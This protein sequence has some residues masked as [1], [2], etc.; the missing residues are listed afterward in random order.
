MSRT[1]TV[2][3][4]P[5]ERSDALLL[6]AGLDETLGMRVDMFRLQCTDFL[7]G[8]DASVYGA[9][10]ALRLLTHHRIARLVL[11]LPLGCG[12]TPVDAWRLIIFSRS[13]GVGKPM[14][15]R[16]SHVLLHHDG[17]LV[18]SCRC[19]AQSCSI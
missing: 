8:E 2:G 10:A 6:W 16:S 12:D 1:R 17:V 4:G 5:D 9:Y 7:H 15:S 18:H 11:C 3:G 19:L 14:L 13:G